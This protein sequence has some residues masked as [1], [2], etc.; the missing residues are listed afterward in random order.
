MRARGPLAAVVLAA[1]GGSNGLVL[2][3]QPPIEVVTEPE[4]DPGELLRDLEATVLEGYSQLSLGNLEAYGD[5]VANETA[6][7]LLRPGPDK[8]YLGRKPETNVEVYRLNPCVQVL[9]RNLDLRLSR[10]YTV[11]WTFDEVSCRAPDP[12]E[13]RST[14]IP[15][16]VT[17]VYER[18]LGNWGL[19]MQH[20]SYAL[21]SDD[22]VLQAL[23][24]RLPAPAALPAAGDTGEIARQVGA[25]LAGILANR[26][27]ERRTR[28][29]R[30]PSSLVLW[31][32]PETEYHG[33]AARAAPPLASLY[34]RQGVVEL[35][36]TFVGVARS[37]RVVWVLANLR[38]RVVAN[39]D[40]IVIGLRATYVFERRDQDAGS[41]M[42]VSAHVSAP[43]E[44]SE[45]A[46]RVFGLEMPALPAEPLPDAP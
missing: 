42:Q 4:I 31:P 37:Q 3:D 32:G 12:Y 21:P 24:G 14:S 9:S 15:L 18:H 17:A 28:V 35:R 6:I 36:D 46:R 1:C 34:G 19:V 11:G 41:W 38:V 8:I 5:T 20:V 10:D 13:G 26:D 27:D 44:H 22:I 39:G 25:V 7:G 2:D 16:R 29:A 33:E 23:S 43:I 45:L 30:D 40:P